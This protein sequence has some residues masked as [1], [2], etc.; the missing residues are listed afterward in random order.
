MTM[1]RRRFLAQSRNAACTVAGL[2]AFE[3]TCA[4][5]SPN[6]KTCRCG[7]GGFAD[8]GADWRRYFAGLDHVQVDALCEVDEAVVPAAVKRS[9]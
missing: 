8:A 1:G 2:S 4:A 6:E 9:R 7:H 5:D 3:H